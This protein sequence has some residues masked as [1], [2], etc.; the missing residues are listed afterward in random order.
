MTDRPVDTI[1]KGIILFPLQTQGILDANIY[2]QAL[3]NAIGLKNDESEDNLF[4]IKTENTTFTLWALDN[5]NF[6]SWAK[7]VTTLFDLKGIVVPVLDPDSSYKE[8]FRKVFL[9]SQKIY[10]EG[11]I[12]NPINVLFDVPILTI[13][14][15]ESKKD[16][17]FN[18]LIN[19]KVLPENT[20]VVHYYKND[21]NG[22]F[23]ALVN[24]AKL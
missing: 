2:R 24:F 5:R 23:D 14:I 13:C 11:A 10:L 7:E 4:K 18:D 17:D 8:D 21:L 15:H 12:F 22:I 16:A 9:R 20:R 19:P 1:Q 3:L 6:L